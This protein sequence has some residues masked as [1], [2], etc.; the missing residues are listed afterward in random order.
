VVRER[1][2]GMPLIGAYGGGQIAPL[3]DGNGQVHNAA[4]LALFREDV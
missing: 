1:F 4:V 3:F 2:P